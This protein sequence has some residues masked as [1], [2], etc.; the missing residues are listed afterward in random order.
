LFKVQT[1]EPEIRTVTASIL[2]VPCGQALSDVPLLNS[3]N[4]IEI[5]DPTGAWFV[6]SEQDL[7]A[8][9]GWASYMQPLVPTVCQPEAYELQCQWIVKW[10][11]CPQTACD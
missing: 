9:T 7:L 6:G 1:F 3:L 8:R 5:C 4:L 10:L 2:F 11:H